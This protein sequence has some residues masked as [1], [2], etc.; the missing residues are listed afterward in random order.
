MNP[1][2][3]FLKNTAYQ[4]FNQLFLRIVSA[5]Y[6]I[7]I[8]RFLSKEDYGLWA[9]IMAI[10]GF[11]NLVSN[12]GLPTMIIKTISQFYKNVLFRPNALNRGGSF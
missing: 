12:L 6:G 4:S 9:I 8:I 2:T 10:V 5:A 7:I 3:L 1:I 11:T